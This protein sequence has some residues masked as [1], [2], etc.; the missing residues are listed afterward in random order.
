MAKYP[1]LPKTISDWRKQ[2]KQSGMGSASLHTAEEL[3]SASEIE[4]EQYYR[5]QVLWKTYGIAEFSWKTA[6]LSEWKKAAKDLLKPYR[7][8]KKYCDSLNSPEIPESTFALVQSFQRQ[9]ANINTS[10]MTSKAITTPPRRS[11]R[12]VEKYP[13]RNYNEMM[14]NME[15]MNLEGKNRTPVVSES[16]NESDEE[17]SFFQDKSSTTR[18]G[19]VKGTPH[20]LKSPGDRE[21]RAMNSTPTPDEQI[22]NTALLNFLTALI[23][24]QSLHVQWTLHRVPLRAHF[25]SAS[26]EARTDGYLECPREANDEKRSEPQTVAWLKSRP[27][28]H[29][30]LNKPG[31]RI[32]VSQDRNEIYIIVAEYNER[33]LKYLGGKEDSSAFMTMKEYGPWDTGHVGSMKH[34][35]PILVA[36]AL[37]AESDL[38]EE[39][40]GARLHTKSSATVSRASHQCFVVR[41]CPRRYRR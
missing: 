22:V 31:R 11:S 28:T 41:P 12:I 14:A 25:K 30:A 3:N 20:S 13:V 26:Y 24:H 18:R 29:G 40:E 2:V 32:H 17:D 36:I 38:E 37:R 6:G 27:D 15:K 4:L 39:K 16:E 10:I 34:L 5:L 33:Y 35:G 19:A 8:W 7:S 1:D 23:M 21:V 9:A